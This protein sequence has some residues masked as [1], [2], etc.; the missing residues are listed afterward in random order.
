MAQ[1]LYLVLQLCS[2]ES[3]L[4]VTPESSKQ[5]SISLLKQ[6]PKLKIVNTSPS[7]ENGFKTW[8]DFK[9]N[10]WFSLHGHRPIAVNQPEKEAKSLFYSCLPPSPILALLSPYKA[11]DCQALGPCFSEKDNPSSLNKSNSPRC[12]ETVLVLFLHLWFWTRSLNC[13]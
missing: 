3:L 4:L 1:V 6:Y 2:K 7:G 13:L 5:V 12:I 11:Q 10:H 8:V 9:P